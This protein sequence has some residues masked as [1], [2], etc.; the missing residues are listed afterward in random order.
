MRWDARSQCWCRP[1]L[2]DFGQRPRQGRCARHFGHSNQTQCPRWCM[3][4]RP[5][6]ASTC[7]C[8]SGHA[9]GMPLSL[10]VQRSTRQR[11]PR[12]LAAK[13]AEAS[14]DLRAARAQL[15]HQ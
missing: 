9:A 11:G 6:V 13:A 10:T 8:P 14:P 1:L 7:S 2:A 3:N 15:A 5:T 4:S 12:P